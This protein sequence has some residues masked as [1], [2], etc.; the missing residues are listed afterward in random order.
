MHTLTYSNDTAAWMDQVE[1]AMD[2]G[3]VERGLELLFGGLS[4][5]RQ[6]L[7]GDDWAA[8]RAYLRSEHP[9]RHAIYED[10]M[11]RRAFEKPRGYAGDAVMMDYLYGIHSALDAERHASPIGRNVFR[12]IQSRPAGQAVRFRRAHIAGL[13]DQL[14]AKSSRPD[15]LAI[16][17]GHLREAELSR[18]VETGAVG[19]FVALDA[20]ADSLGEVARNYSRFGVETLH[21]SVR[22]I[23]ARKVALGA[24]D[25][26]YAAGLYDYLTEAVA[27]ALTARMFDLTKP[28]GQLL[29]PNFAPSV[30]DRAYMETYMDW[31]LIYR[32][33]YDMVGLVDRIDPE[34]IASL[35]V[36]RD[37]SQA[38]VYLLVKKR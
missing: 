38:V 7:D 30:Q 6:N 22:H 26:V 1:A 23:L 8:C 37:P 34:A 10:P 19:R 16:A 21:A 29:I 35:E 18:A 25:F 27:Q 2:H 20:D 11:T 5:A 9:L 32:D 17:A 14:A 24:F 15:V 28:G 3:A 33:E 12:Y 36:Y 31:D 4:E 13:V